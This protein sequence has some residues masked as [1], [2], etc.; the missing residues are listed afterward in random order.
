MGMTVQDIKVGSCLLLGEYGVQ[1]DQRS[2]IVWLKGTRNNDFITENAVD[3]LC[4]DENERNESGYYYVNPSYAQSNINSFLNSS[5]ENWFNKTHEFDAAPQRRGQGAFQY[6]D[7]PGFLYFFDNYEIASI[8]EKDFGAFR[9]LIQLP[10]VFDIFG[11][12]KFELFNKKGIRPRLTQDAIV[13]RRTGLSYESFCPFWLRDEGT[14]SSAGAVGRDACV[15]RVRPN[16]PL[17]VRPVCTLKAN[18][19]VVLE[20]GFFKIKPFAVCNNTYT[21]EELLEFLGITQP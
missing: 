9:S 10:S 12:I 14:N 2:P 4:F 20:G 16:Y 8:E 17:G 13:T 3:Y 5:E 21:N 6:V 18:T 11:D 15:R 1:S 19:P 7:H